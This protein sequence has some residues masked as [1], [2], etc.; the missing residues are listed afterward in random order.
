MRETSEFTSHLPSFS[1]QS[2]SQLFHGP[3]P[4]SP[5]HRLAVQL[6]HSRTRSNTIEHKYRV[7]PRIWLFAPPVC[8]AS[9]LTRKPKVCTAA[10]RHSGAGTRQ[11]ATRIQPATAPA[12]RAALRPRGGHGPRLE[13]R[14][15]WPVPGPRSAARLVVYAGRPSAV[16]GTRSDASAARSTLAQRY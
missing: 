10:H 8:L 2:V 4:R 15:R 9:L 5:L 6:R 14:V 1:S 16:R 11:P 13:G 7:L 12:P 3:A